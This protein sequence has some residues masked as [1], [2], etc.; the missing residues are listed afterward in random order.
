VVELH[1]YALPAGFDAAV[2]K[3]QLLAGLH[4]LYPETA[5]ASLIE[6]RFL[7]R[8]DCPAFAPGSHAL[9]PEVRTPFAGLCL[10]GDFVQL[11]FPSALMERAASAG[12]LAAN[13][14][15]DPLG[16]APEPLWSVATRGPLAQRG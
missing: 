9:R 1:A 15:L 16:V 7:L 8:Q 14:L 4:T 12:I 10:A 6:D 11:P 13:T 2:L 5:G 3:Q